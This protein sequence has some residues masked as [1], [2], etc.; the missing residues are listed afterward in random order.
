MGDRCFFS[1][2]A[3]PQDL[4]TILA[5]M[6]LGQ[7][8]EIEVGEGSNLSCAT[9]HEVNYGGTDA[10]AN[11]METGLGFI[12]CNGAGACYGAES[13]AFFGGQHATVT[14]DHNSNLVLLPFDPI[15]G[16]ADP[17]ALQEAKRHEAIIRA[18]MPISLE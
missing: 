12:A 6:D 15:A 17:D 3:K 10:I 4:N 13:F 14:T 8:E 1:V 16:E 18:I 9:F 5:A 7:P 11:A 2:Q